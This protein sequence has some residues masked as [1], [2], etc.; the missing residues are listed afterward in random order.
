MK[1]IGVLCLTLGLAVAFVPQVAAFSRGAPARTTGGSFPGESNCT[2]CHVG[3]VNSGQG[4]LSLTVDG[5]PTVGEPG[6]IATFYTPGETIA[7]IV[8][9][10]DTTKFR[11]GFQLTV[12]SGDGCG[13]PGSLAAASS[14]DG[15][16]IKTGTGTCGSA[17]SEVQWATHQGPRSGSAATFAVDWTAPDEAVGPVTIAV[18]VNGAD[19]GQDVRNDNIYTLQAVLQPGATTPAPPVISDGGVTSLGDSDP[20][21]TTGAAGGIA[22]I[23]GTDFAATE[24]GTAGSV[25][26]DGSLATKVGGICVEVNQVRAPVLHVDAARV[27]I[28]IPAETALGPAAVQVIRNCDPASDEPQ[29]VLSNTATFQIASVQ[30]VLLQLS[31]TIPGASA[32]H[33]DFSLVGEAPT[34]GNGDADVPASENTG[35]ETPAMMGT[36][37][38]DDTE[39]VAEQEPVISPAV[40]GEVVTFFGTGFGPT[41]PALSTGEIPALSNALASESVQLMFGETMVPDADI[42]YAGA[43]PGVAG[44]YQL[45]ARVPDTIA[46]GRFAASVVVDMQTSPSGP[47][48]VIGSEEEGTVCTANLVVAVGESCTGTVDVFGTEYTGTFEVE[49]DQACVVIAGL[50]PFCGEETLDP[51]NLGLLVASKQMD[52]TWVITKFGD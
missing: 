37:P 47:M 8:S 1:R 29:A 39:T 49:E 32:I 2:R 3:T 51:L 40:A 44:L 7:L 24:A 38:A 19:G 10:E 25:D 43:T 36:G 26:P 34:S 41:S 17:N 31:E 35:T 9:F 16:G 48:I 11:V 28:Q 46:A 14:D 45:S 22:V 33:A 5:A 50:P 13:Q 23:S 15:T 27:F 12:R 42:V 30:P 21:L 6:E 4:T 18:A 52:G 20:P